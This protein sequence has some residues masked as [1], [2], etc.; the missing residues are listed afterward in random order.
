MAKTKQTNPIAPIAPISL[1]LDAE[2]NSDLEEAMVITKLNKSDL[3]RLSIE[4]GLKIVL[5]QLT[6]Q[7]VEVAA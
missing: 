3:A 7:P 4:R 1:R 2:L 6:T 5:K